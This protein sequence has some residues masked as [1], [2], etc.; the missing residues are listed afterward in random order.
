MFL[1]TN[2]H[3]GLLQIANAEGLD[4]KL[5]LYQQMFMALEDAKKN[6]ESD[7]VVSAYVCVCVYV[8]V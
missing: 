6:I 1:P 8:H 2:L 5:E 4:A 3:A 7:K